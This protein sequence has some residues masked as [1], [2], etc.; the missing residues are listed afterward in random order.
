MKTLIA[1]VVLLGLGTGFA[2][3]EGG[4]S[5]LYVYETMRQV[6][7]HNYSTQFNQNGEQRLPGR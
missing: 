7:S 3:A 1:T 4:S 5:G 2:L 6:Q